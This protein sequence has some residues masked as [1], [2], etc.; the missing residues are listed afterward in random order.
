MNQDVNRRPQLA[1][2]AAT[3]DADLNFARRADAEKDR[4]ASRAADN[5]EVEFLLGGFHFTASL[6]HLARS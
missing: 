2:A 6:I 4:P 3:F 1:C 5:L